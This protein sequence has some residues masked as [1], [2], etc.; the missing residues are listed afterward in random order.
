MLPRL[1][2]E[3]KAP[4]ALVLAPTRELAV[5]VER[6]AA[7]IFAETGIHTVAVYGGVGYKK[8]MDALREG[9][10]VIVGTPGRVLDHLLR[11]TMAT[12]AALGWAFPP[13]TSASPTWCC[14]SKAC[15]P[16]EPHWTATSGPP[17]PAW[18]ASLPLAKT[19]WAWK[20]FCLK[21]ARTFMG[22]SWVSTHTG[23]P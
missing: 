20:P 11:R 22:A 21:T 12:G 5:Q 16:R 4:Q 19:S 13:R 10:Q 9:A 17:L 23:V 7:L 6:E 14:P 18:G 2:A 1:S 15:T 8:Q 3:L